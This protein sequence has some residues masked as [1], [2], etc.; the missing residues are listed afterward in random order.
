MNGFSDKTMSNPGK[1]ESIEL[2]L[3]ELDRMNVVG[4]FKNLKSITLI[5]VNIYSIEVTHMR[6]GRG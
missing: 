6:N 1:V 4:N 3:E 2:V 5:N